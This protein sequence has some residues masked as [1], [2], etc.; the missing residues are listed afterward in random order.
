LRQTRLSSVAVRA[1]GTENQQTLL[2]LRDRRVPCT[3]D[4]AQRAP[5][6]LLR[7]TDASCAR[8]IDA[9]QRLVIPTMASWFNCISTQQTRPMDGDG[10]S[11]APDSCL[12]LK[13]TASFDLWLINRPPNQPFVMC[14]S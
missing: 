12:F 1:T 10:A 3:S 14:G 8:A 7:A 2:G 13:T 4:A 6:S 5:R 11:V 9:G